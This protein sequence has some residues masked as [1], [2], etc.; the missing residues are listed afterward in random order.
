MTRQAEAARVGLEALKPCP[1]SP[2]LRLAASQGSL[3]QLRLLLRAGARPDPPGLSALCLAI[4]G[5]WSECA[6]AL[7][8]AGARVEGAA[9]GE[10]HTPISLAA[11]MGDA[12]TLDRLIGR[13]AQVNER[14]DSG[15]TAF[16]LT[17]R[18]GDAWALELLIQAG[19]T[20]GAAEEG[21][22]T[23]ALAAAPRGRCFELAWALWEREQLEA[24]AAPTQGSGLKFI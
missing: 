17:L 7:M 8:E 10:G 24:S 20:A 9:G 13:G 3:A 21:R 6:L 19:A 11:A 14:L 18:Q 1:L 12:L 23:S 5:G 15:E 4:R 2:A 22:L 16:T